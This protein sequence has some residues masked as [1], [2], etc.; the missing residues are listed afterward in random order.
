MTLEELAEKLK[1]EVSSI[2]SKIEETS[3][4]VNALKTETVKQLKKDNETFNI[5]LSALKAPTADKK[6]E[7]V[8][9]ENR[10]T[11]DFHQYMMTGAEFDGAYYKR[12]AISGNSTTDRKSTR[13]NSSHQIISY[14][15][16][17]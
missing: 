13:L 3:N 12:D 4:S 5:E 7:N 6:A 14:A 11:K 9:L 8:T 15:V 10:Y 2:R 1:G 17:C 16:F